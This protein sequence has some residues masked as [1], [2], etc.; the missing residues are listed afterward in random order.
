M[1]LSTLKS[2]SLFDAKLA[3]INGRQKFPKCCKD[4]KINGDLHRLKEDIIQMKEKLYKK[5]NKVIKEKLKKD[6][7]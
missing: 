7:Y 5:K 6:N 3:N 2:I 4:N 1:N